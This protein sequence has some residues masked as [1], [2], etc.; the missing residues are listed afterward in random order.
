MLY[1][2]ILFSSTPDDGPY[3]WHGLALEV[4][5]SDTWE[6]FDAHRLACN[7]KWDDGRRPPLHDGQ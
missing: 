6:D 1:G 5:S 2:S 3:A 4:E 7:E